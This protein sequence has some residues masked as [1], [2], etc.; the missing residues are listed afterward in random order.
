MGCMTDFLLEFCFLHAVQLFRSH[1]NSMVAMTR[2]VIEVYHVLCGIHSFIYNGSTFRWYGGI[3]SYPSSRRTHWPH[4][5]T[6]LTMRCA[7]RGTSGS[8]TK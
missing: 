3:P 1:P 4:P 6:Y 2:K 8:D 5:P 7:R